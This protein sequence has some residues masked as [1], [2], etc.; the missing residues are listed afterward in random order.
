MGHCTVPGLARGRLLAEIAQM[1]EV[2]EYLDVWPEDNIAD[3]Y[4]LRAPMDPKQ[5]WVPLKCPPPIMK[6]VGFV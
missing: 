1:L 6:M 4:A 3:P 2:Q 5:V